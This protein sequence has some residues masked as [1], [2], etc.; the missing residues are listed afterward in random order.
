VPGVESKAGL[1]AAKEAPQTVT[2]DLD[3]SKADVGDIAKA[4]SA[5][6]TPHKAKVAPSAAL[7]VSAPGLTEDNKSK[8]KDALK[9]VKGVDGAETKCDVKKQEIYVHLSAKGG[10]KM[11]DITKAL[12]QFTKK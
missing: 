11:A 10:A 2:I 3:T 12:E 6:D 7:I 9:D 1:K 4:I 8:I 5:C